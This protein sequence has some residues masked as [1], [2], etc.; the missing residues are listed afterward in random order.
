MSNAISAI[1]QYRDLRRQTDRSSVE[2]EQSHA[3][4]IVCRRGC[5]QCCTNLTVF[6][7]EFFSIVEEMKQAGITKLAFDVAE[8]CG[9]LD[10]KGECVIYLYRPI[11][12]RT[13]GLPLAFY[14]EQQEGYSVTFCPKNFADTDPEELDFNANT[15]LNLDDLNDE[16][17]TIHLQFLQEHPELHF[18]ASTR[19][20]LFRL[21]EYL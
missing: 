16:L 6:P 11:I 4:K 15:T 12:C 14:D 7:V 8:A 20:E 19:M 17:F 18:T 3:G 10:D 9:Y 5:C 21:G 2:L 1:Q 13:Q